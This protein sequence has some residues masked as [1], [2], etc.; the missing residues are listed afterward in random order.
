MDNKDKKFA[1]LI[2]A[3][4]ISWRKVKQI[5][6]EIA[7][8]GVPTIKRAYRD[9]TVSVAEEWKEVLLDN[10]VT[11]IQQYAYTTGK[12][13]TDSSLII[14]AMDL[15]HRENI[16][17]F[18]IVSSDSDYTRLASRLREAGKTVIGIGERKTPQ[19]FRKACEKFVFVES[20]GDEQND[21]EELKEAATPKKG[22]KSAIKSTSAT[23]PKPSA[24]TVATVSNKP[25]VLAV[26]DQIKHLISTTIETVSD[27]NGWAYLGTVGKVMLKKIPEFDPRNFGFKKLTD[28]IRSLS[29]SFEIEERLT[30]VPT[31]KHMYVK[32]LD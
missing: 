24:S 28:L 13:S 11:P 17:G 2:D 4:N 8:T 9:W 7:S 12:N 31:I 10:S 25:G 21:G 30:E 18:C 14:D 16:D 23:T 20:L 15:L 1:V 27:D 3:D 32:N 5:L 26:D 6:D 29:G 19:P 22:R